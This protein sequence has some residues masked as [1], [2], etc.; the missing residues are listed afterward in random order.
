MTQNPFPRVLLRILGVDIADNRRPVFA[1]AAVRI[2][3]P[4]LL[5]VIS[6]RWASGQVPVSFADA[7]AALWLAIGV[8]LICR[9]SAET[10]PRFFAD[11][12]SAFPEDVQSL[13]V[14]R[15]RFERHHGGWRFLTISIPLTAVVAALQTFSG[16]QISLAAAVVSAAFYGL[17]MFVA[18]YG[19]W[20][21]V[22]LLRMGV[23]LREIDLRLQ[24]YH[25]DGF[26]GLRG[27]GQLAIQGASY[28]FT[29]ALVVPAGIDLA[30]RFGSN[31]SN[32]EV[33][34][35]WLLG[36]YSV[37]GVLGFL[38]PQ[39]QLREKSRAEKAQLLSIAAG[40]LEQGFWA[41]SRDIEHTSAD[42][43]N[44]YLSSLKMYREVYYDHVERIREW[45][46]DYKVILQILGSLLI[47]VLVAAT[48]KLSEAVLGKM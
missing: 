35:Y 21:I 29:G 36:C 28:F 27:F 5:A 13:K 34:T 11:I 32:L 48:Q 3:L 1:R 14:F 9:T 7:A 25:P 12:N 41:L 33:A 23:W 19:F 42:W 2:A 6:T 17:V 10:F 44:G 18:G 22:G 8:T 38:V 15:D 45:P 20:A 46:Y 26:G 24:P 47:P 39:L 16:V 40:P 31:G 4:A 30:Q 37:F 43:T